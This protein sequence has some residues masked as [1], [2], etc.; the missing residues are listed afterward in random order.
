[1]TMDDRELRSGKYLVSLEITD[2]TDSIAV[3]IFL[4]DENAKKEFTS[5]VK[6]NTFVRIK[7]VAMYDTYD[8]QVEISRVDGMR[9]YSRFQLKREKILQWKKEWNFIVIPK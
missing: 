6:K 7:G 9:L 2:F 3:K 4:G 8:R 1:M 5:K